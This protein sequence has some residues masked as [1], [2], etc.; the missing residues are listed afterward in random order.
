MNFLSK[1]PDDIIYFIN[2]NT[3][4]KCHTCSRKFN[5]YFY[6]KQKKYYYCSNICA[7]YRNQV[8]AFQK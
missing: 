3:N 8:A 2:D 1:L 5:I 7:D 6:K 4:I